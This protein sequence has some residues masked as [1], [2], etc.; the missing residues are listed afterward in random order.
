M[1]R[2][3]CSPEAKS[4]PKALARPELPEAAAPGARLEPAAAPADHEP[5]PHLH[6]SSCRNLVVDDGNIA[7][8]I[9][10]LPAASGLRP[11]PGGLPH[12]PDSD[13]LSRGQPGRDDVVGHRPHGAAVRG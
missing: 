5:I 13:L 8:W 7:G 11:A 1:G 9:C 12:D 3:S 4:K 6:P 2:R 10:R